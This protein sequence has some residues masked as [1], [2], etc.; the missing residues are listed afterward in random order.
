MKTSHRTALCALLLVGGAAMLLPAA[1]AEEGSLRERL[2]ARRTQKQ[3]PASDIDAQITKP[4]DYTFSLTHDGLERKYRV[5]VPSTYDSARPG[6]V[7]V[8]LHGGGGDMNYQASDEHYGLISKSDRE[9]FIAVF[10]NGY[11]KHSSGRFATWNA[12]ACCGEARDNKVDDVGFIKDVVAHVRQQLNVDRNRIFAT[13]MSNGAMMSYRLACELSDTF[14]AIAAVAGTDGTMSCQ[15]KRPISVLH[16]HA[17]NDDHVLFNGGAGPNAFRD[18]TKVADFTSVPATVAKWV[19]MNHCDATPK[20]VLEKPGAYCER[21]SSCDSG[22]KV[23]LC[24][25]D[26]GG[27]SWPG[28]TKR[29]GSEPASTAISADDVMWEFFTGK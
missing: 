29:R 2:K 16:I 12:G 17:K 11:S 1:F 25:T 13:G 5:H 22:T 4:G 27:H 3:A 7:L 10:P 28:G 24:V 14:S 23:E 18:S 9:G 26:T 15:P 8:A 6:A 21:Y 20:R 19:K